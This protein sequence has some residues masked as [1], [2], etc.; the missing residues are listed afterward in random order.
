MEFCPVNP[1]SA[2]PMKGLSQRAQ[3]LLK[4]VPNQ[5]Y[6]PHKNDRIKTD[7]LKKASI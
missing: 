4:P 3:K 7:K 5:V 1:Q 2:Q 6:L